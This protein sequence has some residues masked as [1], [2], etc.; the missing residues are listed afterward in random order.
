MLTCTAVFKVQ[1]LTATTITPAFVR[2]V[3]SALSP[4]LLIAIKTF[5]VFY[6]FWNLD[7]LCSVIPD[8]S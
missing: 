8:M 3:M 5:L 7:M 6:N 4:C 1:L 2:L